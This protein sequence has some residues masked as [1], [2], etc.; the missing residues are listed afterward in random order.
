MTEALNRKL[1]LSNHPMVCKQYSELV[2]L[3]E[4]PVRQGVQELS[5]LIRNKQ[6][7]NVE[8]LAKSLVHL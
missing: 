8:L 2:V 1:K 5:T 6:P 4:N 3:L 7:A